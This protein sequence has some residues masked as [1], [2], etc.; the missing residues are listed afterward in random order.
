MNTWMLVIVIFASGMRYGDIEIIHT[1]VATEADCQKL[2][3]ATKNS[4][5]GKKK[6]V[7]WSNKLSMRCV[8]VG[9]Y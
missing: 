6:L 2:K 5:V 4:N 3:K 7:A 9:S 1:P 8:K